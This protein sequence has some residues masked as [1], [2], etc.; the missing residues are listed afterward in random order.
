V[1]LG[2]L[3]REVVGLTEVI[4]HVVEFPLVVIDTMVLPMAHGASGGVGAATQP[5]LYMARLANISNGIKQI[6][7]P[8][9]A[10]IFVDHPRSWIATLP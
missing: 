7:G 5:S 10:T 3:R 4:R 1:L 6:P 2:F 9:H 8:V